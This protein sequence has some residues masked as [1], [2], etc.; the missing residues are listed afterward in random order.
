MLRFVVCSVILLAW[1]YI[2][3]LYK[4]VFFS[5]FSLLETTVDLHM[6]ITIFT[7]LY[8]EII[9]QSYANDT[10]LCNNKPN[11]WKQG[12]KSFIALYCFIAV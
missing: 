4:L 12:I 5:S 6:C 9:I 3:S 1:V 8:L 10:P 11:I 7:Y 2:E